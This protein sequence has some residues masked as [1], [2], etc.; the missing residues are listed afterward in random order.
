MAR[1]IPQKKVSQLS[2]TPAVKFW[3]SKHFTSWFIF[4]AAFILFANSISG[5][6]NLDDDL[7]TINHRLTSKGISAIPE[8]FTSHYFQDDQG[9]AYEY[10]PLVLTSFAIEHQ[11]FGDNAHVSH[12]FNV[13]FYALTCLVLLKVLLKLFKNYSPLLAVAITLLFVVHPAHTEVVCSIKNRD[14]ILSLLF[15][16]LTLQAGV[17]ATDSPKW[18]IFLVPVLFA[19]ALM[20]KGT[21]ISF[22]I[23][24]P[25]ALIFFTP[26]GWRTVLLITALLTIPSFFLL[27]L[28]SV[29]IKILLLINAMALAMVVYAAANFHLFKNAALIRAYN[30]K[31]ALFSNLSNDKTPSSTEEPFKLSNLSSRLVMPDKHLFAAAPVTITVGLTI[32]YLLCIA[33]FHSAVAIIPLLILLVLAWRGEERYS[34]WAT[35][36]IGLCATLN[37]GVHHLTNYERIISDPYSDLVATYLVLKMLFGKKNMFVPM[38]SILIPFVIIHFLTFG[39]FHIYYLFFLFF[40]N[41]KYVLYLVLLGHLATMLSL[42]RFSHHRSYSFDYIRIAIQVVALVWIKFNR[43]VKFLPVVFLVVALGLFHFVEFGADRQ[44]NP[45]QTLSTLEQASEKINPQIISSP[46][47]RPLMFVEQCIDSSTSASVKLGTSFSILLRY[48]GKVV[49]PYPLS[50]YYGYKYIYPEKITA[51]IPLISVL[52]HLLLFLVAVFL[53]KRNKIISFGLLIYLVSIAIFANYLEPVA[54]M[55]ADRFLLVPSLGWAIV[56]IAILQKAF[57]VNL[58]FR[59]ENLLQL[60]ASFR[61]LFVA[62]LV[63]YGGFTFSRN[64]D[65]HDDLTLMK[66]D[67]NVVPQS[68]QAQNLLGI[69]LLTNSFAITDPIPQA[70]QRREAI[71]HIKSANA[72][73]PGFFNYNYDLGR[74]YTLLNMTDSALVYFNEAYRIDTAYH[75]VPLSI[76]NIYL[77]KGNYNAAIPYLIKVIQKNPT[78]Y[79][80]YAQ[81][82]YAYFN[83]KQFDLSIQTNKQAVRR[84]PNQVQSYINI[85]TA[86]VNTNNNDSA[87]AWLNRAL[88]VSPGNPDVFN[89]LKTSKIGNAH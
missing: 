80:L 39:R 70:Q 55:F 43:G 63:I 58:G 11:F 74:A 71:E 69:H 42:E 76:A 44:F 60:P 48:L 40:V 41:E 77:S 79:T 10:R 17:K 20:G 19:L 78:D 46:Q 35:I 24:I 83:L 14:E 47:D 30:L 86:Y 52:L 57:N 23:I 26:A 45:R 89:Q 66:H 65:W 87:K 28:S 3:H 38:F 88:I 82:S 6:Y 31:E 21:V 2:Q 25:L 12:F 7:V 34:W 29:F 27:S 4:F 33:Q 32:A 1:A 72:L 50:F 81:L 64:M 67:I 8:I 51:T 75:D 85:A 62:I 37:I 54:G 18:W 53:I 22:I 61:Y 13:L 84:F 56:L 68:V 73:Y 9:Y 15:A 16:L 49:I 59:D 36:M 5:G